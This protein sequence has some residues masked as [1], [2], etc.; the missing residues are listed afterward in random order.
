MTLG[1]SGDVPTAAAVLARAEETVT[2]R[3]R[4]GVDD[5]EVLLAWA[6]LHSTDP[7]VRV[8]GGDALLVLGGDGT[9]GVRD[10][11]LEEIS[12]ARQTHLYATRSAMADAL[13]LRHRLPLTWAA[14]RALACEPWLARK[15]ASLTRRLS[16]SA[17]V[18]VDA[19]V[20]AA[21]GE[22]PGRV[23]AICEAKILQADT[24]LAEAEA[25]AG[26][27]TR[28]VWVSG[29][30]SPGTG[31]GVRTVYA[32]VAPGDAVWVDA[33]VDRVADLL[34]ADPDLRRRHHPDLPE[35][36]TRDQLRAAAF[37]WLARPGD[38]A[39]LLGLLDRNP[40]AA[41]R[42]RAVVYVHLHEAALYA[43]GEAIA[44]AEGFGPILATRLADLLGHAHIDLKPVIDL[45]ERA[46]VNGYE[47]PAR[48]KERT[49]LRMA[50]DAF[51][52]A[53]GLSRRLD[54]DHP[55]P[56]DPLGPPGQTGDH[57]DAPLSRHAHR[58]KTHQNYRVEQ[59]DLGTYLWTTPHGLI[60]LVDHTGT[61]VLSRIEARLA[62]FACGRP[63][64]A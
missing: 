14:T 40:D 32:R 49:R 13:D 4:A 46:S 44:R 64:V 11:C 41:V 23:L 36:P 39:G 58:A 45:N 6:D 51:P 61:R 9:P 56:Y 62:R 8:E 25:A 26:R 24:A 3:R 30:R 33:T 18:V 21:L 52:H 34:A 47:H 1:S 42:P 27:A 2:R 59:L 37:G 50:G 5:L 63:Q 19:A 20:A 55:V 60:R 29:T 28:G 16:R 7:A 57:N 48:V 38:L 35:T 31:P 53:T 12:I 43:P 10:L 22:A 54:H 15:V 17:V